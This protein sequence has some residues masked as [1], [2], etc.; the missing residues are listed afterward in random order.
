MAGKSATGE[1]SRQEMM[2][3][4]GRLTSREIQKVELTGPWKPGWMQ[5]DGGALAGEQQR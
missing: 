3:G 4:G 2:D 5:E 1:L